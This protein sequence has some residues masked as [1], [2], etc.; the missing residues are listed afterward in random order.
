MRIS[1]SKAVAWVLVTVAL[2]LTLAP[3][4]WMVRTAFTFNSN[5]FSE[6]LSLWPDQATWLNFKKILGLASAEEV[7]LT[8]GTQQSFDFVRYLTNSVVFTAIA[9]VG[10]VAFSTLAAYAF[11][12]LHFR[13][14][15][16]LFRIM[17]MGLLVPPIF[18]LLPNFILIRDLGLL[19]SMVGLVAPYILMQ[20]FAVF[21]MRQFFLN[22]PSEL[23]D[24]ARLDG[25]GPIAMFFRVILPTCWPPILTLGLIQ[26]VSLWNEYLWPLVVGRSE[27][28]RVLNVAL[29]LFQ[30]QSPNV[31]PDWA[32][33]MATSTLSV[34][35]ILIVLVLFGKRII[36]SIQMTGL[37]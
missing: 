21:F 1:L 13:G 24:A 25:V 7:A 8:G 6:G 10:Q 29:S 16:T 12:R 33:L 34:I 18:S 2:A 36:G 27:D 31:Q 30:Q 19:N 11:A 5:L 37:K 3:L 17:L 15:E 14:R 23:E 4:F 35:P 9:V 32:G 22:V 28:T 20:P 26:A